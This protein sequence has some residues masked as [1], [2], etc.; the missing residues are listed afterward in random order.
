MPDDARR[1]LLDVWTRQGDGEADG[2]AAAEGVSE[3]SRNEDERADG[4]PAG[5]HAGA[6]AGEHL[7]DPGGLSEGSSREGDMGSAGAGGIAGL[8][9]ETAGDDVD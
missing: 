6:L 2:D 3:G 7:D 5:A 1:W 4:A 8:P 9:R